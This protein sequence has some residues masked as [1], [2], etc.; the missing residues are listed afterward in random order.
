MLQFSADILVSDFFY[1]VA[2]TKRA[3]IP[4]FKHFFIFSPIS[5]FHTLFIHISFALLILPQT[6]NL[7]FT[8]SHFFFSSFCSNSFAH[9]T[10][11]SFVV[12]FT[13]AK[14]IKTIRCHT[15]YQDRILSLHIF[16]RR[17]YSLWWNN[18][19]L[20]DAKWPIK[21]FVEGAL[22]KRKVVELD[23]SEPTAN[24]IK[25]FISCIPICSVRSS[26]NIYIWLI[27]FALLRI[28]IRCACVRWTQSAHTV[29]PNWVRERASERTSSSS[30]WLMGECLKLASH[31]S[32]IYVLA[33]SSFAGINSKWTSAP[34][35]LEV[36]MNF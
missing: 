25:H 22:R 10:I 24:I 11:F 14:S 9:H 29:T 16:R 21:I 15:N 17:W 30:N 12:L 18:L 26:T 19:H 34:W 35:T 3:K 6:F 1:V 5:I 27:A 33:C 32:P 20:M 28:W 2:K 8:I 13:S 31:V 4:R 7:L 23:S 36:S